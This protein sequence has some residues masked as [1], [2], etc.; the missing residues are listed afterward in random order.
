M[1]TDYDVI[2]VGGGGAGLAAAHEAVEN[3]ARVLILDAGDKLGGSTNLS[4][5]HVY[6]AG[7][8]VQR[9]A[10]VEGDRP[11]DAF[12][13]VMTLNQFRLEPTVVRRL[14]EEAPAAVEW[15]ISLG[16]EFPTDQLYVAGVD[17]NRRG[18]VPVGA[19]AAIVAAL[20][21]SIGGRADV[22]LRTRVRELLV[23]EGRVAGVRVDGETIRAHAVVVTTGGFG[24]NPE[25]LARYYPDAAA[26]GDWT[27][28]IGM[29]TSQGD[30]LELGA[31]A[32]ADITGANRGLLLA[33]PGFRKELEVYLPS[34]LA[35]VNREGRRFV[36][37]TMEY[38]IMAGL[39]KEQTGGECFA[40]FDE[41]ARAGAQPDADTYAL[42]KAGLA[43]TSWLPEALAE[44]ARDKKLFTAPTLE[45]LAR[46]AGIRW[47]A[48]QTTVETYNGYC[49]TRVDAAFG[50]LS[51]DWKPIRT[52]PF[53]AARM[54]PAIVCFTS[55]GLRI[56]EE[57]RV[58]DRDDQPIAG[59]FAAGESAGG[60]LGD[61]IFGGGSSM[62]NVLVYGRI[63]GRNAARARTSNVR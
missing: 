44:F 18:H 12:S 30:H 53:Y 38:N 10:G 4:G 9:A 62:S 27:W 13:Y 19:G 34:W 7:T 56:D 35:Y 41:A 22:A 45:G 54:R 21:G 51:A 16:V 17:G 15:L 6:A 48:L 8:S 59:L 2:V 29:P 39:I 28:Y 57:A 58:H 63:A 49:E 60:V 24:A 47:P 36:D 26:H 43:T 1:D 40:I 42:V 14:C 61:R 52:G 55:M 31:C 37:E 46:V 5:G 3:G 20:E 23:E 11:E 25:L 32:G 33:T 50:K